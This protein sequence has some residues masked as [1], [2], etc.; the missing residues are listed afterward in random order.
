MSHA[1]STQAHFLDTIQIYMLNYVN[2]G[3]IYVNISSVYALILSLIVQCS[4]NNT[5]KG[6]LKEI[7]FI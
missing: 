5:H 4:L 6:G 3:E 2:L 1:V 7:I